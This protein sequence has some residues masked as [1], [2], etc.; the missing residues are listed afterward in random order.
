MSHEDWKHVSHG[1]QECL[2]V[3]GIIA[4]VTLGAALAIWFV[5]TERL[6]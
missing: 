1:R 2:C 6:F 3:T 4:T 5:L